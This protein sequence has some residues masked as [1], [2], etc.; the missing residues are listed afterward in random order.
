MP[1]RSSTKFD[2]TKFVSK[3]Q[4]TQ[5]GQYNKLDPKKSQEAGKSPGQKAREARSKIP[6]KARD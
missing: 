6:G 1:D 3:N 2:N 4:I 5:I